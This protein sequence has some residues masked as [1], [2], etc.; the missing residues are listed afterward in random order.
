MLQIIEQCKFRVLSLKPEQ[1]MSVIRLIGNLVQNYP[2]PMLEHVSR[3]K[4]LLDYFTFM[5]GKVATYLVTALLPLIKSS[6]DLQDYTILVVRK[7]MFRREDAVRHAATNAILDLILAEKQS[8][9]DGSLSLQDSSSQASCSQQEMPCSIHGGLFQELSALLQRC[10]YQQAKVKEVMYQGLVKLVLVDPSAGGP[11]FDFLLPHFLRF[12]RED[13]DV[14]LGVNLCIKVENGRAF[15]DEP[16]D[17]LLYC[18]SLILVLQSHGKSH[19]S[20]SAWTCFGFSLSQENEEGKNSSAESFSTAL[21]KIR[22][23]LRNA[24]FEDILGLAQEEGSTSLAEEKRK[25]CSL[26]L[27]GIIEVVLNTIANELDKAADAAK[28]ALEKELIE[29]IVL[30]D[31]LE[32]DSGV[33]RQSNARRVNVRASAH[34]TPATIPDSCNSNIT[35]ERIPFLATS[36]IFQLLQMVLHLYHTECSNSTATSQKHSQSSSA[37]TLK[38]CS[39]I[40]SFVLETTFHQIKYSPVVGKEDPLKTLIY[41]DMKVLGPPLLKLIFLLKSRPKSTTDQKRK[42]SK[43]RKD[44]EEHLCLALICLRELTTISLQNSQLTGLLEDLLSVSKLEYALD[45]ESDE[46]SR[47][48]DLNVRSKE[49]FIEKLLK[50]LISELLLLSFFH[51]V[52]I[53]C[54]I[55]VMIG[56]ELPCKW[57]NSHG[58]WAEGFCKSNS[59]T[60]ANVVKSVVKLAIC[61]SSPPNDLFVAQSLAQELLKVT[62]SGCSDS[63]EVSELYPLINHS[64]S[65]TILSCILQLTEEVVSDMDWAIKKV[66]TFSLVTQKSIH[67]NHDEDHLSGLGFEENLYSRTEALVKVLSSF[68]LMS[69]KDPQA[70]HFLRLATRL[71]KHLAQMSKL[72]IAPKGCKQ[73]LPSLEFQRLVE[74]TCKQ[75]TV[76]LYNFVAEMQRGQLENA[77]SKGILNKIKRENKCIPDLI[78]Q[79]EDYEKYLIQLS[80]VSKI[81]LLRHAKRSTSRD[82]KILD[83][84]GEGDASNNEANDNEAAE[85]GDNSSEDSKDDDEN[86]SERVLSPMADDSLGAADSES[87]GQNEHENENAAFIAKRLKRS[88]Q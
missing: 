38:C 77:S 7:A 67:V 88:N 81:N 60:N 51:E 2:Y 8:K 5:H 45:Y 73:L 85:A 64:T 19:P 41:G 52:E 32:K 61:L 69:L 35:Q 20:D 13:S 6:H 87:D 18:V 30:H 48:D 76:P 16:L 15:I 54:D 26:I 79:I 29:Y 57:K 65:T 59:I 78:F 74:L 40:I 84:V 37:K 58:T 83:T 31:A 44:V 53:L 11:I 82:F 71:Y 4:E 80:K 63:L 9:T 25:C 27:L 24:K 46:S 43:V 39:K 62:G 70:E 55:I 12:F 22:K 28:G 47:L 21:L 86:A 23:F 49:L 17:Y 75:L 42:E 33:S 34:G 36:S 56:N 66:K 10:L 50:P 14:Q 1:S 72:R 3:L 68:V